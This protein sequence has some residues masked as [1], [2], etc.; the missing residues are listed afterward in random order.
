MSDK[1]EDLVRIREE[2]RKETKDFSKAKKRRLVASAVLNTLV[3]LPKELHDKLREYWE[4]IPE[5]VPTE[6][7]MTCV[8]ALKA[9]EGGKDSTNAYVAVMN[10]AYGAVSI[11][12]EIEEVH[13]MPKMSEEEIKSIN[14]T[15]NKEF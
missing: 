6:M 9:I 10:S 13:V 2:K 4:T 15:L 7:V 1:I 14:D 3:L 11:D 12:S 5:R 8:Q